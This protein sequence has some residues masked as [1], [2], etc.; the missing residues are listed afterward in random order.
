MDGRYLELFA[1]SGVQL[2]LCDLTIQQLPFNDN[3]F[4]LITFSE[5]LEHLPL[6]KVLFVIGEMCRVL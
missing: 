5:V 1:S 4:S 2:E 6:E 3:Y